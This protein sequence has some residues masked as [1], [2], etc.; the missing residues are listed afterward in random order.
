MARRLSRRPLGLLGLIGAGF[1]IA[2]AVIGPW[3][4]PADPFVLG[5]GALLPPGRGHWLG[6]DDLGR[7]LLS[8]VL[9]GARVSPLVGLAVAGGAILI[10][11]SV[12]AA[13]G[14]WR[15]RLDEV[16]MR[17]TE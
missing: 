2:I 11:V 1:F 13:A 4:A 16:L 7:D 5:S 10:G 8:G 9:Y 6:T 17:L 3:I 12:G 15:G 14:Y